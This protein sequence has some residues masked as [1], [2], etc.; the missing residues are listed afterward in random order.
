MFAGNNLIQCN[1]SGLVSLGPVDLI[2]PDTT[3]PQQQQQQQQ[4]THAHHHH[5]HQE[6]HH[7]RILSADHKKDKRLSTSSMHI[8]PAPSVHVAPVMMHSGS[9]CHVA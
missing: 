2:H 4:Q 1:E 6:Q 7:E 9:G 3:H 8:V 5:Q